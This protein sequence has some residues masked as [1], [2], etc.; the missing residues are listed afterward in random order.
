MAI[1][2][3]AL[4]SKFQVSSL[5]QREK[6]ATFRKW[7]AV[8]YTLRFLIWSDSKGRIFKD[9]LDCGAIEEIAPGE[10]NQEDIKQ[11]YSEAWNEFVAEF[12]QAF[13]KADLEEMV[14]FAQSRFG[15]GLED[16]LE[17]NKQRS[18]TRYN[19]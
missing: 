14:E 8:F 6:D 12:D 9:A 17:L 11:V 5:K 16:L 4:S 13:I 3:N 15:M 19:R 10:F 18:A 2:H 1:N 7:Q